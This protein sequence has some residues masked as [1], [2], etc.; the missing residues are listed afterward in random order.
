MWKTNKKRNYLRKSEKQ[1]YWVFVPF[2]FHFFD[3]FMFFLWLL[4]WYGGVNEIRKTFHILCSFMISSGLNII[5]ILWWKV[6]ERKKAPAIIFG[7]VF[8]YCQV[9]QNR[10]YILDWRGGGFLSNLF[11]FIKSNILIIFP[12]F[13]EW[14]KIQISPTTGI[15]Q[16]PHQIKQIK[17]FQNKEQN[18]KVQFDEIKKKIWIFKVY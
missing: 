16:P 11:F 6:R 9:K 4:T 13:S 15:F 7:V 17:N 14:S 2:L 1:V 18:Q 10:R 5:Q 12:K 3:V 8:V